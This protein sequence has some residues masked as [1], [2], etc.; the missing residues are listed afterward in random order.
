M[1]WMA[2]LVLAGCAPRVPAH[3]RVV[4][5]EEQQ[6]EATWNDAASLVAYLVGDD[7]LVRAPKLPAVEKVE[8]VSAP[9][10]DWVREVSRLE[11]GDGQVARQLQQ[12]EE[13][14]PNTVVVPLARGYRLRMAENQLGNLIQQ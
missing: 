13:R 8:E 11:Q 10:A 4:P 5:T 1:R 3:L 9:I 14:Y 12:L 2:L 7:P 6:A